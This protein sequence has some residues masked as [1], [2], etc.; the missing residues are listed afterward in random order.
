LTGPAGATGA[1]GPQGP[2]G[3]TGPAGATGATGPQGS[4]GLTGPAGA[5]G[6]TGPQGPIGLTG[7][8]G[9]TG[10]TGPQG[11]IGLTGPAGATGP[12]GIAG[13]GGKTNAGT[14]VTISGAGTDVSPYVVNAVVP[15][16]AIDEFTAI[17]G[18]TSFTLASAPSSLS[19]VK[20]YINGVRIDKD[21]ISVSGNVLTYNSGNNGSY[22]L[23]TSDN[24]TID[25]LK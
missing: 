7:P 13:I 18:Q 19:K 3:L 25:Y 21:A 1:T 24:V 22:I 14:N 5:T 16:Q 12:Q 11:P 4:I 10:D 17:A 2:I 8:A 9:A 15:Q 6:A 20:L 23:M